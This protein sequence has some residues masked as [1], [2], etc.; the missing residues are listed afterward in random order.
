MGSGMLSEKVNLGFCPA[1]CVMLSRG[2]AGA[3]AYFLRN[4][5][6]KKRL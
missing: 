5:A 3:F 6:R 1:V 2:I 4:T